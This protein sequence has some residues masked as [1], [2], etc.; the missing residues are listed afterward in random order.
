MVIMSD[1]FDSSHHHR[2]PIYPIHPSAWTDNG[3]LEPVTHFDHEAIRFDDEPDPPEEDLK[4]LSF[5]DAASL[6]AEVFEWAITAQHLDNV[7]LTL[8]GAKVAALHLS[9]RPE[10]S[11]FASQHAIAERAGCTR[12]CL[13]KALLAFRDSVADYLPPIADKRLGSREK[14]RQAQLAAVRAGV[15]SS[16]VKRSTKG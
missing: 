9:L 13:S 8:V 10:R 5:S 11:P 6:L 1:S 16:Q 12:Q 4:T 14:Y 7:D 15:H 3:A 2:G